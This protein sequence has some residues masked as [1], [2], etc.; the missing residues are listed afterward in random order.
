MRTNIDIDDKLMKQAM[1]ATG[2]FTKRATVE[3]ALEKLIQVKAA[4]D[5]SEEFYR[6]QEKSRQAAMRQGRLEEWYS[7]LQRAGNA[8][9]EPLHANQH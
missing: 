5:A 1:K 2:R 7:E 9:K 4:E 6:G 3:A 8:R